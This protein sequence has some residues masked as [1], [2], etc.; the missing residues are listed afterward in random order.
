[1]KVVVYTGEAWYI[2]GTNAEERKREKG[3]K[4]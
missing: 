2:H 4:C 3:K 1:M